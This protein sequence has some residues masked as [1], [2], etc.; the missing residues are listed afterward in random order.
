MRPLST[1]HGQLIRVTD[2]ARVVVG[3]ALVNNMAVKYDQ[4]V[5]VSAPVANT[6]KGMEGKPVTLH[7]D[8]FGIGVSV[9][10][11]PALLT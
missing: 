11:P 9:E 10:F 3:K 5:P 6:C 8:G 4:P 7:L 1:I 2:D